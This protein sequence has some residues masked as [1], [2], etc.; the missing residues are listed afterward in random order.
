M[1]LPTVIFDGCLRRLDRS[2]G[3]GDLGSEIVV[4]EKHQLLALTNLL[5]V[6]DADRAYETRHL[7]A[8]RSDITPDICVISHLVNPLP[9]PR[10]PPVGQRDDDR[11]AEHDDQCRCAVLLPKRFHADCPL[12]KRLWQSRCRRHTSV[13]TACIE[14]ASTTAVS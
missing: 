8:Q 12:E 9:L 4:F 13:D 2:L 6:L 3:L 11:E 1:S 14:A 5:V 7:G 10:V